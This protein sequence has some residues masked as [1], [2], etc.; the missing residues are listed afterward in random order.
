MWVGPVRPNSASM[1]LG[2]HC[3]PN[4]CRNSIRSDPCL[5]TNVRAESPAPSI[6]FLRLHT[7]QKLVRNGV[8]T[9]YICRRLALTLS[10]PAVTSENPS[11][12]G[13]TDWVRVAHVCCKEAMSI[14]CQK[15]LPNIAQDGCEC[16]CK[17]HILQTLHN[18]LC[19]HSEC[20]AE[21]WLVSP[22]EF[23][24]CCFTFFEELPQNWGYG[25]HRGGLS[26][27]PHAASV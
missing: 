26:T 22:S 5:L 23:S 8:G 27:E 21:A 6:W 17:A 4:I 12:K 18:L 13:P 15:C 11:L 9:W 16:D 24:F 3:A 7:C 10:R 2:N 19:N 20:L 14:S 1:A 25:L